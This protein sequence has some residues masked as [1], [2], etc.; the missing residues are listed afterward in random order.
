MLVQSCL[1]LYFSTILLASYLFCHSHHSPN[2]PHNNHHHHHRS[3]LTPRRLAE[4][5]RLVPSLQ[6]LTIAD[7]VVHATL[8][9][10]SA[11]AIRLESEV[12]RFVGF[13]FFFWVFFSPLFFVLYIYIYIYI[14]I[15]KVDKIKNKLNY[16]KKKPR[17][18]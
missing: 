15:L 6:E 18:E 16:L 2:A 12:I 7:P 14:Y 10:R 5:E 9:G 1:L 4:A 17:D 13:S 3:N 11:L 8:E